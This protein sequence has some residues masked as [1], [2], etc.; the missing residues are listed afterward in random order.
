MICWCQ[1]I[2]FQ[3]C[4][5]INIWVHFFTPAALQKIHSL[6][7]IHFRIKCKIWQGHTRSRVVKIWH[8]WIDW[9]L[10]YVNTNYVY[11]ALFAFVFKFNSRKRQSRGFRGLLP[12]CVSNRFSYLNG[13][14]IFRVPT[15]RILNRLKHFECTRARHV[16]TKIGHTINAVT[17]TGRWST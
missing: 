15:A 6:F 13:K 12:R 5:G 3:D 8:P 14:L 7:T 17:I 2:I 4:Q 10:M 16:S 9:F 11:C 1:Q